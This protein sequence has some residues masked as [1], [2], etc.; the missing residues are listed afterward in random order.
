MI[1]GES[2]RQPS[3]LKDVET[4]ASGGAYEEPLECEVGGAVMEKLKK[5][6]SAKQKQQKRVRKLRREG[7]G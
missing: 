4:R 2:L 3:P 5:P 1:L 6:M 7:K